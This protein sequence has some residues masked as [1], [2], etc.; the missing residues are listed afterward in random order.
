MDPIL[1]SDLFLGL[2]KDE[3]IRL[4]AV[5]AGTLLASAVLAQLA[6]VLRARQSRGAGLLL[7]AALLYAPLVGFY[8]F[9]TVVGWHRPVINPGDVARGADAM[10]GELH[11]PARVLLFLILVTGAY[12]AVTF[13]DELLF[14]REREL[15]L[16]WRVP[17]ILRDTGRWM[18]LLL[19]AFG[20]GGMIFPFKWEGIAIFGGTLTIAVSLALGPTLGSLVSGFTLTAERPFDLGDWIEVDGRQG[21]VDQMTWRATRIIT[22][23]NESIVYPNSLLASVRLVNLSRP[24][25]LL[26][27]RCRVGVHY[28]TPPM[29]AREALS[30]AVTGTPG[31]APSPAPAIRLVEFGESAVYWEIRFWIEDL[32]RIEDIRG[33]VLQRIWYSFHRAGIEIPYPIRN[34]V[35][36]ERSWDGPLPEDARVRRS[37]VRSGVDLLRRMPV[38][39]SLPEATLGRLAAGAPVESFLPGELITVQGEPGDCMY[40]IE[41]GSARVSVE[42]Q[43][44]GE[45]P[46]E[47]AVLGAGEFFGEMSLL[48]GCPRVATVTALTTVRAYLLRVDDVAPLL[49]ETPGFAQAMAEFAAERK[50]HLEEA[51][52]KALEGRGSADLHQTSSH[53]LRDIMRFFGLQGGRGAGHA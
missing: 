46:R 10:F 50:I 2:Q 4:A 28:R 9:L 3:A 48:T 53:L 34:L 51:S 7:F 35:T 40:I 17:R 12:I 52:R 20:V 18:V 23:D 13:L 37:R 16:G 33:D 21:R 47:L 32:K 42:I 29:K 6:R 31:V 41:S 27:V 39:G 5:A 8:V 30:H 26:G 45:A 11:M 14:S 24:D 43:A 1:A 36:R 49:R 22:R 38:F 44:G 19:F 15:R 25:P